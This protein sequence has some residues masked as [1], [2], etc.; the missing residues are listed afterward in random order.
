MWNRH[1]LEEGLYTTCTLHQLLEWNIQWPGAAAGRICHRIET[2]FGTKLKAAESDGLF[3]FILL[4]VVLLLYNRPPSVFHPAPDFVAF[5]RLRS[6]EPGDTIFC[7]TL[8]YFLTYPHDQPC[9]SLRPS[10]RTWTSTPLHSLIHAGRDT[11]IHPLLP[12]ITR[13]ALSSEAAASRSLR[14]TSSSSMPPAACPPR[15][16]RTPLPS[17][18]CSLARCM[19]A[20]SRIS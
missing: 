14:R 1:W 6:P 11:L 5:I 10:S 3:L 2:Q 17:S 9:I 8:L 20:M 16:T 15:P 4:V 18:P 7:H 13:P 12:S 19:A